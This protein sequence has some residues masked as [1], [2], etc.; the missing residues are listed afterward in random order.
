GSAQLRRNA[1]FT[2]NLAIGNYDAIASSLNTLSTVSVLTGSGALQPLPAGVTGVSGRV[3]RNGCD[4][5]AHGFQSRQDTA[6]GACSPGFNVSNATPL[7][8]FPENYIVANPQ[9]STAS[10]LSNLGKSNYHSLQTQFTLRPTM[11]IS[12]QTTYTFAKTLGLVP[13]GYTDPTD[14]NADYAPPYQSVRHDV[15]TN[16]TFELP[17]GPNRL[18]FSN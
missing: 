17:I 8:C 4:R 11:G 10:Y 14:R 18:L 6:S 3:L 2:N 9:L 15:R 1:T 12:F 7:R 5:M 16:G 13:G